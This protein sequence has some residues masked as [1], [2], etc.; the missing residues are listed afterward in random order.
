VVLAA[1]LAI[2]VPI[3]LHSGPPKAAGNRR[4]V[5][6]VRADSATATPARGRPS[7]ASGRHSPTPRPTPSRTAPADLAEPQL[8]Y[9]PDVI[10]DTVTSATKILEDAG[11]EVKVDRLGLGVGKV[12]DYAPAGKAAPGS[13]ITIDVGGF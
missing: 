1:A 4:P 5:T 9:V 7:P 2:A 11:F 3:L 8:L 6:E 10:G 13:T 12:F